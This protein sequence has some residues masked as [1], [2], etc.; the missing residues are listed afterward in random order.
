MKKL[1]I[2]SIAFMSIS[3]LGLG[4][5]GDSM[6]VRM[7]D[8]IY[9]DAKG[10]HAYPLVLV[11]T[12]SKVMVSKLG[13]KYFKVKFENLIGWFPKNQLMTEFDY[14]AL[15]LEQEQAIM[16]AKAEK[17]KAEN[18]AK[19]RVEANKILDSMIVQ[20]SDFIYAD[21]NGR[22]MMTY[23]ATGSK[24][25]VIDVGTKYY[26]VNYKIHN[27]W[28]RKSYLGTEADY[29]ALLLERRKAD[30]KAKADK[31]KAE[32]AAIKAKKDA[33]AKRKADLTKKY[34]SQ[35]IAERIMAKKFWLGMTSAMAL[36]S[37]GK[38]EDVNR[39]V[40]SWG[41]HEQWIYGETYLYFE[42][43]VLTSWQ[44]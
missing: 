40:G 5:V 32:N 22:V 42:N 16:K 20:S 6:V 17:L 1:F 26:Q 4:Q 29:Q 24:V 38:P 30:A 10:R 15:K 23:I 13:K 11:T 25:K 34:G 14:R 28:F 19:A 39:S 18:E 37:L 8:F 7:S 35:E 12:G 33:I 31:I 3:V 43:G 21:S 44:D 9:K 36:E 27:G 2:F 41:T